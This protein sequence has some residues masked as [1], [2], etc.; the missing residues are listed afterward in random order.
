MLEVVEAYV[1]TRFHIDDTKIAAAPPDSRG[2][3]ALTTG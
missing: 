2:A 3:C 1:T